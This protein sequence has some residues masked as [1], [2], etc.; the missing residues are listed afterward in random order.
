MAEATANARAARREDIVWCRDPVVPFLYG[1]RLWAAC[2]GPLGR[3]GPSAD[4]RR[5]GLRVRAQRI[6]SIAS[7]T[8]TLSGA[9][10][11]PVAVSHLAPPRLGLTVISKITASTTPVSILTENAPWL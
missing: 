11:L 6:R 10:G 1:R 9:S 3:V 5:H 2:V 7:S 4:N 8:L